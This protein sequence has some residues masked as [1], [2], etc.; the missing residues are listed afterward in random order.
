MAKRETV[1]GVGIL[2]L[3]VAMLAAFTL[4]MMTPNADIVRAA[5]APVVVAV[6]P[7]IEVPTAR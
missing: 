2:V 7:A 4:R 5:S 6:H 3:A 1:E